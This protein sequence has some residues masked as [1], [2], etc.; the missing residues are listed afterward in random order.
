MQGGVYYVFDAPGSDSARADGINDT[1]VIVGR[2][3]Q[4][5]SPALFEG[6]RATN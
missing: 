5:A 4:T 3:P 6:F 2:Y 1:N